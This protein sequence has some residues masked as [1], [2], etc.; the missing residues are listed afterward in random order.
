MRPALSVKV[1]DLQSLHVRSLLAVAR[2]VVY[3]PA[4]QALL[5]ASHE[6]VPP[7][8]VNAT[9]TSHDVQVLSALAL[10]AA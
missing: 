8:A 2:A 4:T 6:A 7:V 10:P 1:P 5:T 3:V 9:P